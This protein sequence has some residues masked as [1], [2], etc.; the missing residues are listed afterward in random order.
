MVATPLLR[1]FGMKAALFIPPGLIRN[2]ASPRPTLNDGLTACVTTNEDYNFEK[3]LVT[4]PEICAMQQSGVWEIQSHTL[5]HG[6]V[7]NT[8]RVR[9]FYHPRSD[10]NVL[11]KGPATLLVDDSPQGQFNGLL[12]LGLPLHDDSPRMDTT[13]RFVPDPEEKLHMAEYVHRQ[14]GTAFFDR[15]GWEKK[16]LQTISDF[17]QSRPGHWETEEESRAAIHKELL[18]ARHLIESK[19]DRPVR[20]LLFPWEQ[21][22][23]SAVEIA[24]ETGHHTALFG[25]IRGRRTNCPGDDLFAVPRLSWKFIPLLPGEGRQRITTNLLARFAHRL[26]PGAKS[27][28]PAANAR[29]ISE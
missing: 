4:W 1:K 21:G 6:R 28:P 24:S 15:S 5:T 26:R 11:T 13:R 3:C 27:G 17:R 2:A 14:G 16:L 29:D 18:E 22:S 9:D 10:H 7:W 20:H 23:R 19:T 25:V 8:D 12:S